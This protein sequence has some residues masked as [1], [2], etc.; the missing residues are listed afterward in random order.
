ML[1]RRITRSEAELPGDQLDLVEVESLVD[2][3]HQPEVLERERDDLRRRDLQRLRELADADELVDADG[4]LLALDRGDD[5][6]DVV[7]HGRS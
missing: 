1:L 2:G 6:N 5:P 3:D 7:P 4:L